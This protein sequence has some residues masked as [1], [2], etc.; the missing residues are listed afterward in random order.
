MDAN[1]CIRE[2]ER[3]VKAG[4]AYVGPHSEPLA[5]VYGMASMLRDIASTDNQ[6]DDIATVVSEF[7]NWFK[8]TCGNTH[9][10]VAGESEPVIAAI[11]SLK[12]AFAD[13]S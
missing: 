10:G 13:K 8:Q 2:I 6:R 5:H 9:K 4:P 11:A 7:K 3:I 1:I 12:R